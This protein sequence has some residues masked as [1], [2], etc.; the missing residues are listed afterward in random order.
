MHHGIYEIPPFVT[1]FVRES[2]GL[3]PLRRS[4]AREF[5]LHEKM[6]VFAPLNS[7]YVKERKLLTK[8]LR[9]KTPKTVPVGC[10]GLCKYNGVLSEFGKI[11]EIGKMCHVRVSMSIGYMYGLV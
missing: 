9:N 3:C 4:C 5:E 10:I 1:Q 8:K 6:L 11:R 7:L 2:V